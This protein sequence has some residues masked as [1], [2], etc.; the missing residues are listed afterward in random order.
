LKKVNAIALAIGLNSVDPEHY[1]GW[2]GKLVA[3][4]FDAK[5]MANI[6]EN[7]GFEVNTLLTEDA[8][9]QNVI[10]GISNAASNLKPGDIFMIS[11]SGHGGSIRDLN[12]DEPDMRDETWCLFDGHMIDDETHYLFSTFKPGVR[13]LTL[14]D[15]CHSGTVT[16]LMQAEKDLLSNKFRERRTKFM[17]RHLAEKVYTKNKN[18]YH[19]I[20]AKKF[21]GSIR[22][23]KASVLLLGGCM[24]HQVSLDGDRNGLFTGTMLSVWDNGNFEPVGQYEGY[25]AFHRAILMHM[26]FE[27]TPSYFFVGK[28][29]PEFEKQKPFTI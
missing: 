2:D 16:K 7:A 3:C 15:S 25:R 27:Q 21:A 22:D 14:S 6:A 5:D 29:N 11:Y 20:G 26:P 23:V 1:D 17:P 9:R 24:D 19:D 13:I 4:E 18:F 12:M 28:E 8:T 10:D